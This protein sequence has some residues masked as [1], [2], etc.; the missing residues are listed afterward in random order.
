M[1]TENQLHVILST[2]AVRVPA[3]L[4]ES[5]QR[6]VESGLRGAANTVRAY[7]GDCKRFS[8]W[9]VLH[10]LESLPASVE[11]LVGFLT[12]LADSGKKYATIERH[13]AA[14]AKAHELAGVESPTADKKIKVL[15][16]GIARE[17]KTRQKQAPAFSLGSFKHTIKSIN[18]SV[19]AGLR[20]RA[21]LLLGFTGAFRRSE[22]EAL[23]VEDLA[24]DN[25]G[26]VVSLQQ[27][28]TNQLGQAEEKAIF[29][30]P[31]SALCPIRSLQ[32][33]LRL[34][35]RT[36]GPVFV[37][38]RKNNKL[39][40]RRMTTKYTN[41]IVQQYLGS[42]YTAHSLRASFVTVSKLNGADDSKIMNQTKHKTSAM[43]R[44]YTRLDNV[45]QHNSAKELGL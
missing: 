11:A 32:A 26:L 17:I 44:R 27:S 16:K 12:E 3:H 31:D 36:E 22:L 23:N 9:C 13:A 10:Q 39:T 41:L 29:Y 21:L 37:S 30:S 25:D 34:L 42:Q 20:N 45:R 28:K 2:P 5:T 7:A 4:V 8:A 40:S 24:F 15:L 35:G 43:I 33:W 14:I 38:L 19:P 18:I 1:A 6:Y